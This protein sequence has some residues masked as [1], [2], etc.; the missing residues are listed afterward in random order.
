AT[1][2]VGEPIDSGFSFGNPYLVEEVESCPPRFPTVDALVLPQVLG[3]LT[4]DLHHRIQ[5]GHGV[6]E[7]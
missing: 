2:L 4:S 5:G 3:D 1:E 6:L 7:D